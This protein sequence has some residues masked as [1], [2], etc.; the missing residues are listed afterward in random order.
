MIDFQIIAG[1]FSTSGN[2]KE[3]FDELNDEEM[4]DLRDDTENPELIKAIDKEMRERSRNSKTSWMGP[5]VWLVVIAMLA[6]S[7]A[8]VVL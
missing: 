8:A 1:A 2:P 7:I 6:G 3:I 4:G 5:I